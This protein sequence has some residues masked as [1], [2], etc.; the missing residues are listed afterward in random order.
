MSKVRFEAELFEGHKG[1]TAVIVPIDA[2]DVWAAAAD[3][4]ERPN[5]RRC[6]D[7]YPLWWVVTPILRLRW[8]RI[9]AG[10]G[11]RRGVLASPL[12]RRDGGVRRSE[13]VG[14]GI[15]WQRGQGV[16]HAALRGL[17]RRADLGAWPPPCRHRCSC[18][19]RRC[20]RA[21]GWPPLTIHLPLRGCKPST[22]TSARRF[23]SLTPIEC[24]AIAGPTIRP[25]SSKCSARSQ[26]PW[27]TATITDVA[28][29]TDPPYRERSRKRLA[30]A[31][32]GHGLTARF[33]HR[34]SCSPRYQPPAS[35]DRFGM[36]PVSP[37][38]GSS[39]DHF[40]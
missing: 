33:R 11:P 21:Q 40:C 4:P 6:T 36:G 29:R 38:S 20:F 35:A 30:L 27:A 23:T 39:L 19:L 25:Q 22:A 32:E 7:R 16:A 31:V 24:A 10:R 15:G 13:G 12:A 17:P 1:V 2:E 37:T 34:A 26:R 8:F 28:W 5:P 3:P 18:S 9:R 14:L